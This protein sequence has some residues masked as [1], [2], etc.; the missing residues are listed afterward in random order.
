M[1]TLTKPERIHSPQTIRQI[2]EDSEHRCEYVDPVTGER[3]VHPAEGEPHHIRTRGAGGDDRRENLIHLCG[4]HHRLFHDGNLDRNELIVIV[5]IREGVTPEDI[6]SVLKLPF[7]LPVTQ[8]ALQPKVEDLLQAYI[9]VDEQEQETRFVK[10]QLLDAMLAA[11]AAQKYLSS[12]IGISP[13]Q[14]RELVHVY[15]T[16][17][18]P[19]TRNP[20]LSWYHHRIASHSNQPAAMLV[21]A[22]DETMSTRALRKAILTQEGTEHLVKQEDDQERSKAKQVLVSVQKIL[23]TGSE[24]AK[25]LEEELKHILKEEIA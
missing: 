2:R 5:A 9:Q 25:W 4:W 12:Q 11:G 8:S 7:Q 13:A 19:E 1:E 22:S 20:S 6:A 15:R 14:I 21:K 23:D 17:P 10:G 16:F 18:T 24:A 3:C